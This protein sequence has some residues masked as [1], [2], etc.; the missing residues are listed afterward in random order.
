MH[1]KDFLAKGKRVQCEFCFLKFLKRMPP[2]AEDAF[3]LADTNFCLSDIIYFCL[4]EICS[5]MKTL[6]KTLS[7]MF[8][9]MISLK[10]CAGAHYRGIRLEMLLPCE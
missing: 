2:F 4:A 8:T 7:M 10:Q 6:N 5:A 1:L 9:I 3:L